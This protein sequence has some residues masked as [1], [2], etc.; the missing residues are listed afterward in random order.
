MNPGLPFLP[1]NEPS[2]HED[3]GEPT[4]TPNLEVKLAGEPALTVAEYV[5]LRTEILKL[6]E[7]QAQLL[8]LALLSLGALLGVAV[9]QR[10]SNIAFVYPVLALILSF[11]WLNHAHAIHRCARYLVE[12]V[13]PASGGALGWE[14]FVRQHPLPFGMLGYWGVRSVFMGSSLVAT[15]VG[16]SLPHPTLLTVIAGV[17][18]SLLTLAAFVLFLVWRESS[19]KQL[20]VEGHPGSTA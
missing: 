7:L 3:E 5:S 4:Q 19:P 11:S 13:E 9:Q 12:A 8:S 1:Q 2:G 18:S 15:L 6:I 10:N 16:W 20:K 14:R 17:A